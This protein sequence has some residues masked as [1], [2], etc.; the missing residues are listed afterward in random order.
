MRYLLAL[1]LCCSAS[2]QL[3]VVPMLSVSTS[4]TFSPLQLSG[5]VLWTAVTNGVTNVASNLTPPNDGDTVKGW[6]DLSGNVFP[7]LIGSATYPVYHSSGGGSN[8]SP[9][10]SFAAGGSAALQ[11]TAG[12][13]GR[14]TPWIVFM[15]MNFTTSGGINNGAFIN[16]QP[17]QTMQFLPNGTGAYSVYNGSVFWSP[18]SLAFAQVGNNVWFVF[19]QKYTSSGSTTFLRTNGVVCGSGFT[20]SC[21]AANATGITVGNYFN[22][23]LCCGMFVTEVLWYCGNDMSSSDMTK[24]EQYLANKY[25]IHNGVL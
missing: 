24:V 12:G 15:V 8:N 20:G 9:Y 25:N 19:T 10:L 18:S 7:L 14:A 21:S 2:A 3:P 17:S 6:A 1:L 16:S 5:M 4:S 13:G 11:T 22:R 23:S